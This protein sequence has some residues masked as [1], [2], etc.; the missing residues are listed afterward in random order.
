MS[1]WNWNFGDNQTSTDQNPVHV[2]GAPGSYNVSL[3]VANG[4]TVGDQTQSLPKQKT[5]TIVQSSVVHAAFSGTPVSGTAPLTV[6]FTINPP[7]TPVPG[8]GR[9]ATGSPRQIRT[10]S[11]STVHRETTGSV[12]RWPIPSF[13]ITCRKKITSLHQLTPTLWLILPAPD[14]RDNTVVC[15][16]YGPVYREPDIMGLGLRRRADFNVT[17]PVPHLF[18]P[19]HVYRRTHGPEQ[20]SLIN[21]IQTRRTFRF[22]T[23]RP[24]DPPTAIRFTFTRA[25][26]LYRCPEC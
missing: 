8:T 23:A 3:V 1:S 9:S 17:E 16:V 10:R 11:M 4:N 13:Q 18:C 20:R 5:I 7:D 15:P 14:I 2:Y 19:R 25:G 24:S 6:Q 21:V 12:L 22:K 26:T